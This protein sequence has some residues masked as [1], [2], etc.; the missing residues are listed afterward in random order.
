MI[1]KL[2]IKRKL[3]IYNILIQSFILIVLSFSIYK[4]LH[5]STLEKIQTSLKVIVL[6]IVDDIID[7]K[8]ELKSI[9]FDEEQEYKFK[10]LYIR[11]LET[12]DSFKEINSIQFPQNIPI[13]IKNLEKDVIYFQEHERYIIAQIVFEMDSK[14]YCLQ[15]AT[16]YKMLDTTMENL[17]YILLFIIPIILIFSI[18]GGYFLIYKSF[19]PIEQI[20]Y[21]LKH[22][23]AADLSKRLQTL[24]TNDEIDLLTKEINSL[25][26]RLEI[27]FEK[28]N[29]FSSDASHELKTPLTIIRGEIEIALRKDRT[30]QEYKESLQICLDEVLMI[31]QTI[32]DLFF[33]AKN[34][35]EALKVK[36]EV[37]LDEITTETIKELTPYAKLKEITIKSDIEDTVQIQGHSKLLKIAIKNVLKNAIS[38]SDKNSEVFVHNYK[39]KNFYIIS[40]RDEGIGISK[41][42]Q[43]KIFEKFYRTDK[44]RNKDSGGTGLGMSIVDKIIRISN[45]TIEIESQE[46]KGTLVKLKFSIS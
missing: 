29:Q 7:H 4:T 44:S 26:E 14:K 35:E 30:T 5:L 23:N 27:S 12:G 41:K 40:I 22:I 13:N 42:E 1:N 21:N 24:N 34:E 33:L 31:G 9:Y 36:E 43:K 17:F 6:D 3:L 28:V 39:E 16:D 37:Y 45:A 46:E 19:S 38:F 8:V 25:L 11:L 2:S 15:V 10:P 18:I 20:L 32:D